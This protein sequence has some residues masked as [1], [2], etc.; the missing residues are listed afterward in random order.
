[1]EQMRISAKIAVESLE[2]MITPAIHALQTIARAMRLPNHYYHFH[3]PEFRACGNAYRHHRGRERN[4]MNTIEQY[5]QASMRLQALAK[6][7]SDELVRNALMDAASK[8]A[9]LMADDIL[10]QIK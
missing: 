7:E 8:Y 6:Q 2:K 10:E 1:M 5:R 3:Q 4:A 9:L